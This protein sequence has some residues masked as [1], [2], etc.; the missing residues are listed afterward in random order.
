MS[1]EMEFSPLVKA[2]ENGFLNDLKIFH[3]KD[4]KFLIPTFLNHS[5]VYVSYILHTW[6]AKVF[7][8]LQR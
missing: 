2:M 6:L 3:L 7:S 8:F 4:Y 1:K 5:D